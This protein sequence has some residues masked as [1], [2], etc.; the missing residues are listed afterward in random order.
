VRRRRRKDAKGTNHGKT[1]DLR[2]DTIASALLE[3]LAYCYYYYYYYYYYYCYNN[4]N[5]SAISNVP[6]LKKVLVVICCPSYTEENGRPMSTLSALQILDQLN[7][8][9][10]TW[11]EL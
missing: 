7:K 4:N 10:K 1:A 9:H 6:V 5:I 3:G 8:F 11:Y 2:T